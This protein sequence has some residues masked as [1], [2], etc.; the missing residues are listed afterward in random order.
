MRI[1]TDD[2]NQATRKKAI[3]ALS[4]EVRNFQPGLDAAVKAL[5]EAQRPAAKVDAGNMEDV[6]TVIQ[7]LR[8]RSE[9]RG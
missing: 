9:A 1:A 6:D 3:T 8:D 5:P 4:S 7:Q 2:N